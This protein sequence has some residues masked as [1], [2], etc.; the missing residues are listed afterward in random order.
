MDAQR[1]SGLSL[2]SV[3]PGDPPEPSTVEELVRAA[4]A[5]ADRLEGSIP[6][7]RRGQ[8]TTER[9]TRLRH[10]V[11]GSCAGA[12]SRRGLNLADSPPAQR[13]AELRQ[14][15]NGH[16]HRYYVRDQ[17]DLAGRRLRRAD[18]G[19]AVARNGAPELFSAGFTNATCVGRHT[20]RFAPV[21]HAIP[22]LSLA[23]GFTDEDV[24]DF[25]RKA[26][27]RQ[28]SAGSSEPMRPSQSSMG[29][30]SRGCFEKA[31]TCARRPA[32]T[33]PPPRT[34]PPTSATI[35]AVPRGLR[36][37]APAL[38]E[39]RGEVFMPL[40]GFERLNSEQRG[41]RNQKLF[42]NPR[43]AAAGA[44]RQID[45]KVTAAPAAGILFFRR[46]FAVEG[47]AAPVRYSDLLEKPAHRDWG[48]RTSPLAQRV[49]G[50]P[51]TAGM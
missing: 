23:N 25:D 27:E 47:H 20:S 35:R 31:N 13:I 48:L 26:R 49:V 15:I 42:V 10:S 9:L 41:A 21:H 50:L 44:L 30:R 12:A 33:A 16:D 19:A 32:V 2:F 5:L 11:A 38:V 14:E 51:G 8:L 43:N 17:P 45:P 18:E 7:A 36:G 40:A 24:T 37:K 29:W 46:R 4:R 22:M 6:A 3:L 34:S 39:V 1:F 28:G